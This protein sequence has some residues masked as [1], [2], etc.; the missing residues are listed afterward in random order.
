[1][2]AGD[3]YDYD[4]KYLTADT[5]IQI[6]AAL[7][8]DVRTRM[9]DLALRAFGVAR[10]EGLA[11]IDFFYDDATRELKINEINTIPGLTKTSMFPKVW[12]ASGVEFSEVVQRLLDHAIERHER[13]AKLEAARE[14]AHDGEVKAT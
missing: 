5:Q 14:A 2:P 7:P 8:E 13:K 11:R 4:S 3:F 1:V 10:C 12:E 9:A 6:P